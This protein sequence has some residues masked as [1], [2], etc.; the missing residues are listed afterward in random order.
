M[1]LK[2][3]RVLLLALFTALFLSLPALAAV[4]CDGVTNLIY[5]QPWDQ[6]GNA[7]S[8]QND[9]G[10]GN[11]HFATVYDNF[12]LPVGNGQDWSLE[13]I[14]FVGEYFNP[15]NQGQITAFHVEVYGD[16]AG[17]PGGLIQANVIQGNGGETF[18]GNT[19]GFPT[20]E[21]WLMFDNIDLKPNTP[22]WIA[23]YPDLAFP[24]QWG[25]SSGT[26]G[27]GISYQDFFGVRSQLAV[28]MAFALDGTQGQTNIPEPGTLVLLGTG[29]LGLAGTLR[30]R[31]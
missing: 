8:S 1:N 16:N 22:Y 15:P 29:I 17:Q 23:V 11:G 24:P 27:D 10:G 2:V 12:I 13:S 6:T 14:H 28:D 26:G 4:P 19:A 25:W 9:T 5:C 18:L 21:Y 31:F 20:F 7:Y 30:R 3:G